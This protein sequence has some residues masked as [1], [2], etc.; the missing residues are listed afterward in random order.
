MT[1]VWTGEW[2]ADFE[3]VLKT[4]EMSSANASSK[5][6][7]EQH[8]TKNGFASDEDSDEAPEFDLRTG[9]YVT[10]S[11]PLAPRRIEPTPTEH[12]TVLVKRRTGDMVSVNGI[13]SPAADFLAK[14]RTW[15]GLGSDFEVKYEDREQEGAMIEQGYSGVAGG[16]ALGDSRKM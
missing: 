13:A 4:P 10:K 14:Q 11:R 7:T 8:S 15:R 16:Y 12:S 3:S 6:Q 5:D 2:R 9:R 1:I